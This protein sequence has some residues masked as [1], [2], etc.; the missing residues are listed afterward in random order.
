M[1]VVATHWQKKWV[2]T[3]RNSS[4]S[5]PG[6]YLLPCYIWCESFLRQSDKISLKALTQK[7][8]CLSQIPPS[9]RGVLI[10]ILYTVF[11][12]H[13]RLS[14]LFPNFCSL[15]EDEVFLL[16]SSLAGSQ[17]ENLSALFL[18]PLWLACQLPRCVIPAEKF[19]NFCLFQKKKKREILAVIPPFI[20]LSAA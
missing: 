14:Y 7:K 10:D 6:F 19:P 16:S 18:C 12:L 4:S 17:A 1:P 5:K 20:T 11:E 2:L 13:E 8:S 3:F 9:P 15:L